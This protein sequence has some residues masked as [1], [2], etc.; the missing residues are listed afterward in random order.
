[1]TSVRGFKRGGVSTVPRIHYQSE[2]IENA[3]LPMNALL[4]LR[5]NLFSIE[6][7]PVVSEGQEVKEG[8]LIARGTGRN[9]SHVHSP[10]PGIVRRIGKTATTGG[11]ETTSIVISLE[12]S[13]SVLGKRPERYLWRS[14]NKTDISHIIQDKGLMRVSTG[15]PLHQIISDCSKKDR[16]IIAVNALEMDQYR[17]VEEEIL[18]RRVNDVVD[19]CAIA[20]RM[21]KP[22]RIV[23]MVDTDFPK[24]QIQLILSAAG[25]TELEISV[26]RF[27]RRF[28]QDMPQQIAVAIGLKDDSSLCIL[29]PST[30]VVLHDAIVSNKPHIEQYV[31]IGGGAMKAPAILKARIGTTIGDLI[32]ECGGFSGQPDRICINDPYR[33]V[34]AAD[35][36]VP[37]TR[38]TRSV[39]ALT[40]HET[41]PAPERPCNRCGNC[42]KACP[43]G[44]DPYLLN[45]LILAGRIE[46][47]FSAGLGRCTF[48]GACA[49][50]C[51]SRIPLVERF[52]SVCLKDET[53]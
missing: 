3:F 10:I 43:E 6:A 13:F 15:E 28:P 16:V 49:Y 1:M 31:Y 36:D 34:A 38:S 25:Q 48:C 5:E 24:D 11:Y 40:R 32:E 44:L 12:G 37:L 2:P 41:K 52:K 18:L 26:E 9:S 46:D 53:K 23:F 17:R 33:G 51:W 19:A 8:Q 39:L 27:R 35:L 45:K 50:T 29:E 21:V 20:A 14:L 7:K 4:L 42:L 30:L 22:D 47:A